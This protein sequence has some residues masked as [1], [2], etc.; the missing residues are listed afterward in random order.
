MGNTFNTDTFDNDTLEAM[1][2]VAVDHGMHAVRR[3]PRRRVSRSNARNR[4]ASRL[5]REIRNILASQSSELLTAAEAAA[6]IG[7]GRSTLY[8]MMEDEPMLKPVRMPSG[9]KLWRRRDL[10]AFVDSLRK[11]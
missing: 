9:N 3:S 11:V 6:Y 7:V 5:L 4:G 8:R 2:L 10:L 1:R